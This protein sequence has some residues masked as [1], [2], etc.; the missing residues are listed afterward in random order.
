MEVALT[1]P[2]RVISVKELIMEYIYNDE[3]ADDLPLLA[4]IN[5]ELDK[6]KSDAN[7]MEY[8]LRKIEELAEKK[9]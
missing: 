4:R 8:K 1:I 6:I 3:W 5:D 7:M 2:E 9:N